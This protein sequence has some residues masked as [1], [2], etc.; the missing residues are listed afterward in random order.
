[1]LLQAVVKR[2]AEEKRLFDLV[3]KCSED[4]L[5]HVEEAVEMIRIAIW[6]LHNDPRIRPSMS[7]VVEA[8]EGGM[9]MDFVPDYGFLT[10]MVEDA[11]AEVE[12][13]LS[14]PQEPS[15]FSAPR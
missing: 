12:M 9:I 10:C 3:D 15:I 8:L 13:I 1:M 4:M 5:E 11:P 14:D 6:C 7:M 2:K